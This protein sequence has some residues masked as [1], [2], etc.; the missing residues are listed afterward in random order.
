MAD[1]KKINGYNINDDVSRTNIGCTEDTY[2][3][4]KTYE[5]GDIVVCEKAIYK[6]ITAITTAEAFDSSKWQQICLRDLIIETRKDGTP[7]GSG[8]DF[9]GTV[10]PENYM[11]ADG[12][13]ISRTDYAE[14]FAI[15]GTTYGTGNGSTTFNLPDKRE[16]VSIM[17]GSTYKTLGTITGA[18]TKAIAQNNLPNVTLGVKYQ[19]AYPIIDNT[20]AN[21]NA[22]TE[23][24]ALAF[25]VNDTTSATTTRTEA[26]G[27]GTAFNVMQKSL[28]CNYIIKVK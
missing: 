23:K 20:D 4:S 26:L 7:I 3:S 10:A 25:S 11:F 5:I 27:S 2:D 6:C 17:K 18:N 14:L 24:R 8:M 28:V 15:I 1:V 13:A 19:S 16:A 9:F 21:P 12:S 22:T